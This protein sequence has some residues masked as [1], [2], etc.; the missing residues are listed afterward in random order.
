MK[1][2][3]YKPGDKVIITRQPTQLELSRWNNSWPH[4]M[5]RCIGKVVTI[6]DEGYMAG[7]MYEY[8]LKETHNVWPE[9]VM[10]PEIMP[11]EQL[12]LWDEL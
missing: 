8:H 3:K 4:N 7:K 11:G 1:P 12:L 2:P 6:R 9:C 10:G 5:N